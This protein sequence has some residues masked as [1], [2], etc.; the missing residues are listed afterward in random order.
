MSEATGL[1]PVRRD[2]LDGYP[3]TTHP[4]YKVLLAAEKEG[5]HLPRI[6]MW[7]PMENSLVNIFGMLWQRIKANGTGQTE[8]FLRQHLEPL[9]KRFDRVMG[10]F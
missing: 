8:Y 3:Y 5:R 4:N 2:L 6:P 7:G 10:L 9:A 1:L